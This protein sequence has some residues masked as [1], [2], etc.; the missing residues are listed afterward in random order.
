MIPFDCKDGMDCPYF[1]QCK[2]DPEEY[3]ECPLTGMQEEYHTRHVP[4]DH[5]I[6]ETL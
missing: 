1:Y 6:K 2:D 3:D 4:I 5:L